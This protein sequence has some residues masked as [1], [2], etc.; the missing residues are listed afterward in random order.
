MN[1]ESLR[2]ALSAVEVLLERGRFHLVLPQLVQ[3]YMELGWLE[4]VEGRLKVTELGRKIIQ[5]Q[6]G[7]EGKDPVR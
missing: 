7:W 5:E 4:R 1:I 2:N 3:A 6:R